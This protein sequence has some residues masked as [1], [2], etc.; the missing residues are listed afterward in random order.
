M[1]KYV[2]GEQCFSVEKICNVWYTESYVRKKEVFEDLKRRRLS[3]IQIIALGYGVMILTGTLLLM[4]PFS[5]K[6]A[7]GASFT[8]AFFTATSSSCVTGLVLKDTAVYWSVFG[9][10]VILTL[11]QIGG[12][13]FMTMAMMFTMLLRRRAG[14]REREVMVESIN[15]LQLMGIQRITK[16]IIVGTLIF[17]AA[18]ALLLSIR[19]IPM[20]GVGKGIFYSVF[21]SVSAFCNAGF[22]LMGTYSGEFSSFTAFASD[23]LVNITLTALITIGGIGFFVWDDLLKCGFKFKKYRLHTKIVLTVSFILTFGGAL[24]FYIFERG[25][26][27]GVLA[28]LFDSVTARTAGFNTVDTASLTSASKL[29]TVILMLIGGSP[30]S[31]AGGVKTATVAVILCC[32]FSSVRSKQ[33]T[34][35]FG[36]R[37]DDDLLKKAVCVLFTNLTLALVG[38]IAICALQGVSAIDAMFEA[39]SAIGTVGM[40]T[41]ITR[42]LGLLSKYIV[43]FMMYLGRVGSVSFAGALLEKKAN[44]PVTYP[45]EKIII[46]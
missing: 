40:T 2:K 22:D 3:H 19:F 5:T 7:G 36:R 39:F 18:G 29:L 43:I 9:K 24:L 26:G 44:P 10:C 27:N 46:G 28:A 30:G 42:D 31:T 25:S 11:I 33:S 21:H 17:E 23:P 6:E 20:F 4:L 1:Y 37:I 14:L 15:Q 45:S 16:I 38:S 41:G 34:N 12:L 13:G 32:T 8:T 35:I